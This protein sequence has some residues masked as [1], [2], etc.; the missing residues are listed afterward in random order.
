MTIKAVLFDKDGTL[1]DFLGTFGPATFKVIESLADGD[2]AMMHSLANA[3]DFDLATLKVSP[4]S[5]LIAGSLEDIVRVFAPVLEQDYSPSLLAQVDGLFVKHSTESLAP[6]SFT[7]TVLDELLNMNLT[8]RR[9]NDGWRF[10]PRPYR[11][12]GCQYSQR[13]SHQW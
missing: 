5:V 4:N 9:N 2:E 13:C 8:F 1:I 7:E 10:N 11:W 3:S 6:F 12:P